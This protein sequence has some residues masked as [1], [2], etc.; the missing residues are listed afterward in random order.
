VPGVIAHE[1]ALQGGT[2]LKIPQFDKIKKA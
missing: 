1:S 2:L